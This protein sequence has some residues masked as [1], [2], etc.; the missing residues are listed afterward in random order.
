MRKL[1]IAEDHKILREGLK[2]LLAG[3]NFFEVV[4]EA[5]NAKRLAMVYMA[6]SSAGT[7]QGGAKCVAD[8][9]WSHLR[10]PCFDRV[11]CDRAGVSRQK[12]ILLL[13]K[14]QNFV[15]E[16]ETVFLEENEMRRI[17][18]DDIA[19]DRRVYQLPYQTGAIFLERPGIIVAPNHQCRCVNI[20][21]IP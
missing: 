15:E 14:L 4:C 10:A 3:T 8:G 1:V 18:N 12:A 2:A 20:G 19:S 7:A 17:R 5:E 21:G 16:G 6:V 13:Q 9:D 11:G